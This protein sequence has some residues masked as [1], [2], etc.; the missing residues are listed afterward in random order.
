LLDRQPVADP[1]AVFP[2]PFHAPDAGSEIGTEEAGIGRLVRKPTNC[3]Q[4]QVDRRGR[5]VRLLQKKRYRVT[6]VLLNASLGSEQHQS[7]NS[8]IA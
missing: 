2:D 5:I 1:H 4:T 8:R 7:V 3:G 6:T